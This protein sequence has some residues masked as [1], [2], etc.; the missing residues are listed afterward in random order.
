MLEL[1]HVFGTECLHKRSCSCSNS[2]QF[3]Y[4]LNIWHEIKTLEDSE[5]SC[6]AACLQRPPPSP[7]VWSVPGLKVDQAE[8]W[9]SEASGRSVHRL[10][11]SW[12][13][14]YSCHMTHCGVFLPVG[15][16]Q[17]TSP[18]SCPGS[19]IVRYSNHLSCLLSMWS[20]S[21]WTLSPVEPSDPEWIRSLL[22]SVT[23]QSSW[24]RTGT[25]IDQ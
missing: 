1:V 22:L 11:R 16:P 3:I 2:W 8:V 24:M 18:R 13:M 10:S 4:F 14:W 15:H 21:D 9:P 20:I 12:A 17:N 6:R 19:I 5:Q 23:T 25:S 7:H